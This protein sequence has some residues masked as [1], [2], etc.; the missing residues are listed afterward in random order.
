[1]LCKAEINSQLYLESDCCE[2]NGL[3]TCDYVSLVDGGQC[4]RGTFCSSFETSV[5]IYN[6]TLS[7]ITD[8]HTCSCHCWGYL[9]SEA[10]INT[11]RTGAFKLFKCTFP[12]SKQFKSTFTM[13]FFKY[14]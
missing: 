10:G 3:P 2:D 1:V 9:T 13:C 7:H 8:D 6:A 5:P 12:G 14:L 4:C 11:L